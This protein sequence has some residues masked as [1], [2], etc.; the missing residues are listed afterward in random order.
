M[1]SRSVFLAILLREFKISLTQKTDIATIFFFFLIVAS[2]F[3]FAVGPDTGS[4]R[5]VGPGV[6]WVAA[7]LSSLL[8]L[9]RMFEGDFIDGSLEQFLLSG[10]PLVL[11]VASKIFAHWLFTTLPIV[12]LSPFV[13]MQFGIGSEASW[14]MALTLLIGTPVLSLIGSVG[15]AL[16]LGVRSGAA[17]TA[18]LIIP[19]YIPVLIFGVGGTVAGLQGVET[20]GH[21]SI[22]LAFLCLSLALCPLATSAAL[23]IALE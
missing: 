17:L 15:A 22:L 16:T 2:L 6:V 10:E 23:K 3:P 9:H 19:L 14:I 8:A 12:I 4:L 18:L 11:I 20:T 5:T 1:S 13:G 7:L 21:F